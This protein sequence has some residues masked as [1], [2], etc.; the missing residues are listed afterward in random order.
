M[1]E[2]MLSFQVGFRLYITHNPEGNEFASI[3]VIHG[4]Q[5]IENQHKKIC[6]VEIQN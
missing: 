3:I 1:N 2:D 4:K 5:C 6:Q